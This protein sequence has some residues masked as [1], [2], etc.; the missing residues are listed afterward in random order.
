MSF[1]FEMTLSGALLIMAIVLIRALGMHKLPKSAFVVLWCIALFQLTIPFSIPSQASI[2]N[3]F[4]TSVSIQPTAPMLMPAADIT[5]FAA[6]QVQAPIFEIGT[7][8]AD[9]T[10]VEINNSRI[11]AIAPLVLIYLAGLAVSSMFFALLYNKNRKEFSTSLPVSNEFVLDWLE[12]HQLKRPISIRVSDKIAAPLTY[13][14]LRPTILL[15]KDTDWNNESELNYV[16]AHEFVHIKRFDALTK[17]VMAAALCLHWFNPFVW[18]MYI[19]FN[20]D[21]EI[22]CDEAVINMLGETSKQ[23]YALTLISMVERNSH[24]PALYNNFSKYAIEE[25]ITAIMKMKRKT[26]IGTVAAFLIVGMT[27]TVFAT[28]RPNE[29]TPELELLEEPTLAVILPT[30]TYEAS[31]VETVAASMEYTPMLELHEISSDQFLWPLDRAAGIT[32]PFGLMVNPISREEDFH[33]GIDIAAQDGMPIRAARD[34]YVVFSGWDEDGEHGNTV[35]I[36]HGD[37]FSTMYAHNSRNLVMVDQFVLQGEHIAYVGSTG[38][39]AGPHLHFEIRYHSRPLNPLIFF[40]TELERQAAIVD[41]VIADGVSTIEEGIRERRDYVIDFIAPSE[42]QEFR[43]HVVEHRRQRET[44]NF[45]LEHLYF[46]NGYPILP[47]NYLSFYDAAKVMADEIYSRF[48]VCIDGKTGN[49]FFVERMYD[50]LWIG[51]IF[52]EESTAHSWGNELFHFVIDAA[53]GNVLSL[54]MNTEETPFAG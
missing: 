45:G 39:S 2:F 46:D 3:L 6:P 32:T 21:L 9:T 18:G 41:L 20:R 28:S 40:E 49:M 16:L 19:L 1:L 11:P 35:R 36:E 43:T 54:Y 33:T 29:I 37:G 38:L 12:A 10:L 50:D 22:S 4:G 8:I 13:G 26:M 30:P 17:L 34:G 47:P 27:A 5:N 44:I 53:N 15:P 42:P 48:G 51:N 31:T 25:R 7:A 24:L 23:G 52:C 14:V